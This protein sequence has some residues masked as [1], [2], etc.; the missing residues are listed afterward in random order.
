VKG[1]AYATTSDGELV[2]V[3]LSNGKLT[4]ILRGLGTSVGL[5]YVNPDRTVTQ[6][7]VNGS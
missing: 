5:V 1:A 7:P 6:L 3:N 2:R 4:P